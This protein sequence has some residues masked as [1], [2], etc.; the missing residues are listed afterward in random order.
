MKGLWTVMAAALIGGLVLCVPAHAQSEG[1]R[2]EA[3]GFTGMTSGL[4]GSTKWNFGGSFAYA[5][6]R[7]LSFVGEA[8]RTQLGSSSMSSFEVGANVLEMTGGLQYP[9]RS[10]FRSIAPFVGAGLGIAR[11]GVSFNGQSASQSDF[12]VNGGGGIRFFIS[13]KFG[14][15]PEV[16][17]VHVPGDT[18]IRTTVGLFYQF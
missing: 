17:L 14:F 13:P 15:R 9:L 1:T 4:A 6:A 8:A 12:T 18:Y 16:K 3:A 10:P 5:A 11:V 2:F 7:N